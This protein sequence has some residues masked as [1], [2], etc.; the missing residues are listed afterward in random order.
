VGQDSFDDFSGKECRGQMHDS[1]GPGVEGAI[2]ISVVMPCLNEAETLGRCIAKA[3]RGIAEC[4]VPGEVVVADNGSADGSQALAVACGARVVHVAS[5]GYGSAIQ[6]GIAAAHG[7]YVILGDADDSYDFSSI[8]PFVEK[9]RQGYELVMGNRFRGGIETGAMPFLH[10]WLGN[11][12]LSLLGR[13]LFGCPVRD[14]HCG[15]RAMTRAGYARIDPATP[16]MEF[17]S[18]MVVKATLAGLR[19]TEVPCRL[20]RDGRSRP[21]HLRTWR[22]GW[23][24]LCFLLRHRVRSLNIRRMFARPAPVFRPSPA[25]PGRAG[26]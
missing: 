13:I 15:L 1:R 4:G 24:H 11:P 20:H 21:P 5:R 22:D 19:I 17:A 25:A 14:F 23:R 6:G 10:Y 9:L 8:R 16:G 2:E 12:V 7:K 3:H 26:G 18:E